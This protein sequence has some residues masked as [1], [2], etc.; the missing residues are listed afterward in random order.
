M[1]NY[2]ESQKLFLFFQDDSTHS[3]AREKKQKPSSSGTLDPIGGGNLVRV[4][5]PE[6]DEEFLRSLP[7]FNQVKFEGRQNR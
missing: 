3:L 7:F 6:E 5:D 1:G 4:V 2:C